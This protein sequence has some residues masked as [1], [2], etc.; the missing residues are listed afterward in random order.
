[1]VASHHVLCWELNSGLQEEE[2]VL[3]TTE[4]SPQHAIISAFSSELEKVVLSFM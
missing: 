2:T 3:L 1:M 4:P